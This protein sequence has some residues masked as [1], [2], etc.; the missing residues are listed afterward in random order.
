MKALIL[1]AGMGKRLGEV[2]KL[3]PKSILPIL[4][5]PQIYYSLE[6]LERL[7]VTEV[8]INTHHHCDMVIEAVNRSKFKGTISFSDESHM[9]MGSGGGIKKVEPFFSGESSFIVINSDSIFSNIYLKDFATLIESVKVENLLCNFLVN[10]HF[11]VGKTVGR[12]WVDRNYDLRVIGSS[13][14]NDL[15]GFHFIGVAVY[16]GEIFK[17]FEGNKPVSLFEHAVMPAIKNGQKVKVQPCNW[18]WYET[19]N[20][21]DFVNAN[22]SLLKSIASD[23]FLDSVLKKYTPN[24]TL[25]NNWLVG[26]DCQVNNDVTLD[27]YGVLGPNC[28]IESGCH[29][30]DSVL[31]AN[32]YV[33]NN[34]SMANTLYFKSKGQ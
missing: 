6:L 7:G 34:T 19:G 22:L 15:T 26:D 25:L 3:Y 9:L 24:F 20:P 17:Y 16:S 33:F 28:I 1:A 12:L 29:I 32:S 11:E 10:S 21:L 4:N 14:Q 30:K 23:E 2:G 5:I 27:G 8:I 18:N 31:L 13:D